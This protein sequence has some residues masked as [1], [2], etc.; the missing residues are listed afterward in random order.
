MKKINILQRHFD[1]RDFIISPIPEKYYYD[2]S[3]LYSAEPEGVFLPDSAEKITEFVKLAKSERIKI[4]PRGAGTGVTGGAVALFGGVVLSLER[5]NSIL[6]I[7]ELNMC[8]CVQPGVINGDLKETLKSLGF[9]YPPDPQSYET[10]SL[11]GN[12]ATNAGGPRAIKYGITKDYVMSLKVVT[13]DGK[14]IVTGGKVYKNS[15]GYNLNELFC[16]S[17]GTL[18]I[19]VEA[20]LNIIK[21]PEESLFFLI[22]FR[23]IS[24]ATRFL[25]LSLKAHISFSAL[26][27]IDDTAKELV[28]RFLERTLPYSSDA[29]CYLFLE[30]DGRINKEKLMEIVEKC[31][32]LDIFFAKDRSQEERLWE[33]RKKIAYAVKDYAKHVYKADIVVPRGL[34]PE[35]VERAKS[36][37]PKDLPLACFG[38]IG[39]GNIHLNIL[40]INGDREKDAK[41]VMSA[42]MS[43]ISQLGGFPSGEHGIGVSKKGFLKSFFFKLSY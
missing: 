21:H 36:L 9:Y 10:S 43:L 22:P 7:D 11:G 12:I 6:D 34:I 18:G 4:V 5:M 25:S 27:F 28:E 33:A 38:H 41:A 3:T 31:G 32:G 30:S 17:E 23:S 15:S 2:E 29:K 19:I 40:D 14:I 35:F 26:E 24:D 16:G 1:K 8:V 42:I 37:T 39:D 20:T 13:G